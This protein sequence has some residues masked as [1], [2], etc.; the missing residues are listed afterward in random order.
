MS[1]NASGRVSRWFIMGI[2]KLDMAASGGMSHRVRQVILIRDIGIQSE[3][4]SPQS[5]L[6]SCATH[7]GSTSLNER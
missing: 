1:A 3:R 6:R 5:Y 7:K 4:V 2:D